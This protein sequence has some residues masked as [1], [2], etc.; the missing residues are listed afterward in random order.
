MYALLVC[1]CVVSVQFLRVVR[2]VSQK[3]EEAHMHLTSAKRTWEGQLKSILNYSVE[4]ET[5]P[6]NSEL[7]K[8]TDG[9]STLQLFQGQGTDLRAGKPLRVMVL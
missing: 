1:K 2:R 3:T 5:R 7:V 8:C 9:T 4:F 6:H